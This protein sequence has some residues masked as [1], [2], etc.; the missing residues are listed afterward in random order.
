[1]PLSVA[2]RE[3]FLAQPHVAA[4]SVAAGPDRGPLIVP[5]WYHYVPRGPLWI[6]TRPDSR[7]GR[8]ISA[9]GRFSLLVHR[10]APTTRYV[11]VEGAVT[12]MRPA[13]D[14]DLRVIA[15]RYLPADR[16]EPYVDFARG[17]YRIELAPEHWLS[18]DLGAP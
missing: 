1:M 2:D 8:L 3:E 18:S 5:I 16:V 10:I 14:D 13:T 11:S 6:S 9:A 12:T 4:V 15:S 7:K 17:E